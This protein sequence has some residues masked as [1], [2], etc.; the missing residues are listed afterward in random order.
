M[1]NK[2][3]IYTLISLQLI[4]L[5][6]GIFAMI[7]QEFLLGAYILL[8]NGILSPFTIGYVIIKNGKYL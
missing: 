1:A 5:F 2:Y 4:V 8:L 7:N 6:S 3:M